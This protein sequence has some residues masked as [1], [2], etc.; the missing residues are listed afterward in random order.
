[1]SK[2]IDY[3]KAHWVNP[4]RMDHHGNIMWDQRVAAFGGVDLYSPYTFVLKKE[5]I[6]FDREAYEAAKGGKKILNWIVPEMGLSSGGHINIFRFVMMLQKAGLHNRIYLLQSINFKTAEDCREFLR[7]N[8]ALDLSEI[9][10]DI[11]IHNM[12]FAHATIATSWQTA[13]PLRDFDNTISKFYFV[14]DFE[15]F[16][17]AKGSESAFAE[18]TYKMGYRG[19]TAGN[20]LR[21]KLKEEYGMQTESF[22]FSYDKELYKPGEKRDNVP[23]IFFYARP[24]TERRNFELG[25]LALNEVAKKFPDLEVL[26]AGWDVRNYTVPFRFKNLGSVRQDKLS[27]LYAQC[28]MC[29]VLSSTNLSLLPL[30]IMASNSVPVCTKGKNSEWMMNDSNAVLVEFEPDDIAEKMIYF[31]EHKEELNALRVSGMEYAKGTSWDAEGEKVRI[32]IER[33]IAEDERKLCNLV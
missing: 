33:G 7:K 28:D 25:I 9:E 3:I 19:L 15:P 23:R 4:A 14:Q 8:Y 17:Y 20:W 13:Y 32:A 24:V 26:F 21:D 5:K 6:P 27:D 10:L 18:N 22:L 31:L 2:L 29:L 11:N 1:M 30:E 12:K 16:F